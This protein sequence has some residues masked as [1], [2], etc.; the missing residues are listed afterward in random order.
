MAV[1]NPVEEL[2]ETITLHHGQ[3]GALDSKTVKNWEKEILELENSELCFTFAQYIK[4]ANIKAHE[5]V[6]LD[7]KDPEWNYKFA[8][9]INGAD[10]LAHEQVVLDSKD[11]RWNYMFAVMIEG[12]DK[13][14]H[15]QVILESESAEWNYNYANAV[16]DADILAHGDAIIASRDPEYNYKFART[17]KKEADIQ[18]HYIAIMCADDSKQEEKYVFLKQYRDLEPV[19]DE[20]TRQAVSDYFKNQIDEKIKKIALS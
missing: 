13:P 6:I 11:P 10:I 20:Q 15:A 9:I 14:K 2:I 1:K 4:G 8:K 16:E 12:A 5:E 7:G 17:F 19:D 18:R 3:L